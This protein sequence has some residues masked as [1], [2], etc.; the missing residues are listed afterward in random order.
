MKLNPTYWGVWSNYHSNY[1]FPSSYGKKQRALFNLVPNS[2]AEGVHSID[3]LL[4]VKVQAMRLEWIVLASLVQSY[5]PIVHMYCVPFGHVLQHVPV[6]CT[7]Q[8][9]PLLCGFVP[10]WTPTCFW[11][12][13]FGNIKGFRVPCPLPSALLNFAIL[14]ECMPNT[15][16]AERPLRA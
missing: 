13:S 8:G 1:Y 11:C 16:F 7:L 12:S 6:D 4:V 10:E 2:I 14:V 5:S 9:I 3:I 15:A